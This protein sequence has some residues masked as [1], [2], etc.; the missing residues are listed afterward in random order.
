MFSNNRVANYSFVDDNGMMNQTYLNHGRTRAYALSTSLSYRPSQ[1]FNLSADLR[2]GYFEEGIP[3]QNIAVAG[4]AFSQ[5]VNVTVGLWKGA[6]LTI[7]EY[8]AKHQPQQSSVSKNWYFTTSARLGQKLLKDKLEIS[9]SVQ[10]PHSRTIR[11]LS[12]A[13]TPSYIMDQSWTNINR[14]IRLS[15]SYRFGK[16]GIAVKRTKRKSDSTTEEIGSSSSSGQMG[17]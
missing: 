11:M 1:R 5:S 7:S 12:Q 16:Q 6:R 9:L 2:A 17:A 10:N 13:T 15:L 8:L 14:S 4:W 3:Q